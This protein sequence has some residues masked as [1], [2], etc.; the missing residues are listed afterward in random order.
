MSCTSL[1]FLGALL[2]LL[3]AFLAPLPF[4]PDPAHQGSA[5]P[6]QAEPVGTMEQGPFLGSWHSI[7]MLP[8]A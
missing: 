3:L 2:S 4:L 6:R 5:A 1:P 8:S 7:T